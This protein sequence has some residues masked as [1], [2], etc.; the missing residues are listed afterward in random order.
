MLGSMLFRDEDVFKTVGYLSG[1]ERARL[2]LLIIMLEKANT[3]FLDEPTNHLDLPSK[4]ALDV[5]MKEYDGTV[6]LVSHDRY[7]LNK[8]ADKIYELT[9][10]GIVRYNGNY[11][12][13]LAGKENTQKTTATSSSSSKSGA[14]ATNDYETTKRR[15][16]N[17][18]NK[19][20]K[21]EAAEQLIGETE[22]R[23]EEL[24]SSLEEC[25]SDYDKVK[26]IYAQ[27]EEQQKILNDTYELWNLLGEELEMLQTE[28]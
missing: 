16:A 21:L 26:E 9:P 15:Q 13:Y 19:T 6:F 3:L 1:G 2:L 25:G 12:D 28:E 20:K 14:T 10:S 23:I 18:K 8:I 5:A 4:E 27:L 11:D 24:N 22:L 17:I 7:F